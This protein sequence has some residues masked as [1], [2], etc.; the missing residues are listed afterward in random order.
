MNTL[1]IVFIFARFYKRSNMTIHSNIC[2]KNPNPID[3]K[4][5]PDYI[6]NKAKLEAANVLCEDCGKNYR[7]IRDLRRHITRVHKEHAPVDDNTAKHRCS[8][9][10]RYIN[11]Q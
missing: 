9:C 1:M 7:N 11:K 4:L 10:D 3:P 6:A 8:V 5:N 2:V